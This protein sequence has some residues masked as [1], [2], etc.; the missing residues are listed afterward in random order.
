VKYCK[1][2]K[3][4]AKDT[5]T[6]CAKGHPLSV[7]GG[8]GKTSP[9]GVTA[10]PGAVAGVTVGTTMFTLQGQVQ[11]LEDARKKNVNFGRGLGLLSLLIF[12]VIF[13]VLYQVYSR[14]VLAYAVLED[15][16]F[17][18]DPVAEHEITVR[19]NVKTPGQV[20]FDRR[21]GSGRTEKLD[22]ITKTGGQE[23]VWAWPSDPKTG[24]DFRVISRGRWLRTSEQMHFDV[25][26]ASLGVEVVFLMD[27]TSSM[28]RYIEGLKRNC[29]DFAEGIRKQGI[30]CRLGLIGFGDVDYNEPI[31]TFDPTADID[32]FQANVARL[33]LTDG[34]D[35][36]ES[37]VEALE[38]AL[39]MTFRPHTRVCFVHITDADCHNRE[40]IP[41]VV[42]ELKQK[43][44]V[45]YVVSQRG[46]KPLYGPLCVNGGSFH[47]ILDGQFDEI[48][49]DVARSIANQI[50]SK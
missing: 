49:K 40:R 19:F 8:G 42:R 50:K 21:S 44:I 15:V 45:T 2:C 17:S 43:G 23:T 5:D 32:E 46:L 26:R 31:L 20:V 6:V 12:L 7:F 3:T 47:G 24:I 41:K 13:L 11:Q 9:G 4:A 33:K 1:I 36:P 18:Q 25:T 10:R 39:E 34:G 28:G 22:V 38:K 16:Q 14:S 48:L 37:S 30:D 35:I 27:I 29:S